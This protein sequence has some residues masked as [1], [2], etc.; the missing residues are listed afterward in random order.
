MRARRGPGC[1]KNTAHK[2]GESASALN[3]EISTAAMIVTAIL[4]EQHAGDPAMNPTE[5][6]TESAP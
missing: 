3:A 4:L 6:K 1:R 5:T 2:A